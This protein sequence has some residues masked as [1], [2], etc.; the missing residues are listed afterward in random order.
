MF[1]DESEILAIVFQFVSSWEEAN[2][3]VKNQNY[4]LLEE[5]PSDATIS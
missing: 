4:V 2:K 3:A 1:H 5:N